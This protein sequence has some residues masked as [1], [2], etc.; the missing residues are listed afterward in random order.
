MVAAAPH[1]SGGAALRSALCDSDRA[2]GD[3]M[4]SCVRGGWGGD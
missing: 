2:R 1:R 4:D 3:G